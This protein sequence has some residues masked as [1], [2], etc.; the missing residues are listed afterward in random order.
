MKDSEGEDEPEDFDPSRLSLGGLEEII[1]LH[2]RL[3]QAAVYRGFMELLAP[4]ELTQQQV[5]VLWLVDSNPGVSQIALATTL[6][7]DRATMMAIIDR[8]DDR[9]LLDRAR[10][11][12]D[13]RRQKLTL[14]RAGVELLA[15]AK[16][17]IE[18]HEEELR[19]RIGKRGLAEFVEALKRLYQ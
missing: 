2:M 6:N 4:L 12:K 7:M 3:A 1:G 5:A 14:T 19:T 17:L 15:R 11:K 18:T 8:L 9:D 16:A 10:S 13:R